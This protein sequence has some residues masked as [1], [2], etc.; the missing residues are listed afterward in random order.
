MP[1]PFGAAGVYAAG[2][3]SVIRFSPARSGCSLTGSAGCEW[4]AESVVV[5]VGVV[6]L[7]GADGPSASLPP[8]EPHAASSSASTTTVEQV[9]VRL[10]RVATSSPFGARA[11]GHRAAAPR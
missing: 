11:P 5:G 10:I 7:A 1:V 3:V 8:P 9:V 6:G 4:S 2:I